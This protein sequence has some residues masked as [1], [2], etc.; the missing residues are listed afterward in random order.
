MVE[1]EKTKWYFNR[2]DWKNNKE[3]IERVRE[4]GFRVVELI[5]GRG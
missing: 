5:G 3:Y 4:L 2:F 1:P